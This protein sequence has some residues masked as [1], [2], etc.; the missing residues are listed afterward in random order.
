LLSLFD[1]GRITDR[2]GRTTS[3]RSA[4]IIM[5]SNIGADRLGGIGFDNQN[6][7]AALADVQTFFRPEFFNRIDAV[8]GFNALNR[9]AL[10][11]VTRKEL[12]EISEREGLQAHDTRL[13]CTEALVQT[14]ANAGYDPRYGARPLQRT[15]EQ[16][17]VAPLARFLLAHPESKG[18]IIDADFT[19]AGVTFSSFHTKDAI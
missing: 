3:L 13:I 1:E 2:F 11:E 19:D 6:A 16:M 14:V 8:V 5:T 17:I 4:V 18:K 15:I 12:T 7:R 10:L 9:A